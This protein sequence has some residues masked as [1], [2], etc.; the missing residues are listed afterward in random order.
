[1]FCPLP[2][3]C[4]RRRASWIP[5]FAGMT[6]CALR[7]GWVVLKMEGN[8]SGAGPLLD[9]GTDFGRLG[10]SGGSEQESGAERAVSGAELLR[11]GAA[12]HD[13]ER[14]VHRGGAGGGLRGRYHGAVPVRDH[15]AE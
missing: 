4:L 2:P 3:M 12:V 1:M 13:A 8:D 14:A 11:A 15:P 6:G 7:A 5:A 10:D 9:I